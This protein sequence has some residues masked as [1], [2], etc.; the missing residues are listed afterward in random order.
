MRIVRSRGA[1]KQAGEATTKVDRQVRDVHRVA[2]QADHHWSLR[3]IWDGNTCCCHGQHLHSLALHTCGRRSL[4]A[5]VRCRMHHVVRGF[6][7]PCSSCNATFRSRCHPRGKPR[8]KCEMC[9]SID[10]VL[11]PRVYRAV[12][13]SS[14]MQPRHLMLPN[15]ARRSGPRFCWH[16]TKTPHRDGCGLGLGDGRGLGLGHSKEGWPCSHIERPC[17]LMFS[18]SVARVFHV[19]V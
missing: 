19:R 3:N 14:S 4:G 17:G 10:S 15:W 7:R 11:D 13:S 2:R 9:L 6:A 18:L 1:Q 8:V 16:I 5:T 12:T